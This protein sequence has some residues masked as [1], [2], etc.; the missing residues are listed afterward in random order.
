M[1]S[2]TIN[3]LPS[4]WRRR[5]AGKS[6][7]PVATGMGGALVFRVT[8]KQQDC[9]YLKV[10][11]GPVADILKREVERT[12]WLAA[13][14]IQVP[15]VIA[16]FAIGDI[17]AS[18]M[19]SLGEQTAE[20]ILS[21]DRKPA[22]AAIGRALARLHSLPLDTCPFDEPLTVRLSRAY[23]LV[24]SGEIDPSHFDERNAG[25]TPESLYERLQANVPEREDCVVTHGDA[26]LSNVIMGHDGR[27]GFIDCGHAGRADRYVDLSVLVSELE[28]RFGPQA[29][30]MFMA[31]YGDLRWENSKAEFYRD[32]YELF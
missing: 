9:E 6:I 7:V 8:G 25:V 15:Q 17:A 3:A 21:A 27:V 32:V 31:A 18:L 29:R 5:L 14:G 26:S 4:S 20:D 22:L 30:G 11:I 1:T 10:G 16:H 28:D 23:G 2:D 24:Q 19:S 13:A 12:Q